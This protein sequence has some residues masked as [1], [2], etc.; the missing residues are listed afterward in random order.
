[1]RALEE[2]TCC[3]PLRSTSSPSA[4]HVDTCGVHFPRLMSLADALE[5]PVARAISYSPDYEPE[6]GRRAPTKPT[7]APQLPG[8][9]SSMAG[10]SLAGTTGEN[11]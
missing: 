5:H 10:T 4:A 1:M 8:S 9:R 11:R 7:T 3:I 6:E 2:T